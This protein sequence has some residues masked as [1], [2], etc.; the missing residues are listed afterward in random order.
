MQPYSLPI[1]SS[2]P[3][4]TKT[5]WRVRTIFAIQRK[6]GKLAVHNEFFPPRPSIATPRNVKCH[7]N[8]DNRAKL[9]LD[10]VGVKLLLV[11]YD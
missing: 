3:S 2:L 11:E 4:L 5:P 1:S 9:L 6:D 7:Q 10:L 8:N